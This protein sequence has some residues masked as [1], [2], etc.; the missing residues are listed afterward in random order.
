MQWCT[1]ESIARDVHLGLR[2]NR[3][4]LTDDKFILVGK[5]FLFNCEASWDGPLTALSLDHGSCLDFLSYFFPKGFFLAS[6]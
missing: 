6:I 5:L 1:W 2:T 4:P 3:P